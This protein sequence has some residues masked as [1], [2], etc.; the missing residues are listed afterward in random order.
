[1]PQI[2]PT[3]TISVVLALVALVAPCVT[4]IIN[5]AHQ[6]KMK[7]LELSH[8]Q[9]ER[10]DQYRTRIIDEYFE[11][12]GACIAYCTNDTLERYGK[13]FALALLY[14]P[15]NAIHLVTQ[16]ESDIQNGF[17]ADANRN[18][19]KL[20]NCFPENKSMLLSK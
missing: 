6:R 10:K 12:T 16:I 13:S 18:L 11:N 19:E 17:Y 1:M 2:D 20:S 15:E 14:F 9:N 5:N 3:I 4:S 7:E 8:I